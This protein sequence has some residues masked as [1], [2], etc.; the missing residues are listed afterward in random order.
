MTTSNIHL[1]LQDKISLLP[2]VCWRHERNILPFYEA[3]WKSLGI[4]DNFTRKIFSGKD[5]L[6]GFGFSNKERKLL[7]QLT[8]QEANTLAER[9]PED[10]ALSR[11]YFVEIRRVLPMLG[12][13]RRTG[14]TQHGPY[15]IPGLA[16]AIKALAYIIYSQ[17]IGH[18]LISRDEFIRIASFP[19]ALTPTAPSPNF[20]LQLDEAIYSN[21]K[22]D[23]EVLQ[24]RHAQHLLEGFINTCVH[25]SRDVDWSDAIKHSGGLDCPL[26]IFEL[27]ADH[28]WIL[29]WLF[30]FEWFA[31]K[32]LLC[33]E[34]LVL[35][36]LWKHWHTRNNFI[37]DCDFENHAISWSCEV[38]DHYA[39]W[40]TTLPQDLHYQLIPLTTQEDIDEESGVLD[41]L[42][43]CLTPD[44]AIGR[45]RLFSIRETAT[46]RRIA[47]AEISRDD[48]EGIWKG[49]G[50]ND[51]HDGSL[52]FWKLDNPML[53]MQHISALINAAAAWYNRLARPKDI[54]F[55]FQFI[56]ALDRNGRITR[57]HGHK[58]VYGMT[59]R[60]LSSPTCEQNFVDLCFERGM[61]LLGP[62]YAG[63]WPECQKTL[64][65]D[66]WSSR[67]VAD[68]KRFV[69]DV[70]VGDWIILR[71][72]SG[73]VLGI[74]KVVGDYE[75]LTEFENVGG[76]DMQHARPVTW[77]WKVSK[78]PNNCSTPALKLITQ[79][80][81]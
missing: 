14:S 56:A 79:I 37:V 1:Q 12:L 5:L 55:S 50:I 58:D 19:T 7:W 33:E 54:A 61:I 65:T 30:D 10:V 73:T 70:K 45:S 62:G 57:D 49:S 16:D 40:S 80:T 41:N 4:S 29:K 47:T 43:W 77:L 69:E 63:S 23:S 60:Q 18:T 35:S 66:E 64:R 21:G 32:T 76:W 42:S 3:A 48:D 24:L 31:G 38:A 68:I 81:Y 36:T 78:T 9:M 22:R 27:I 34:W 20:Q 51:Q 2:F 26:P 74:G 46:G 44:C 8:S 53:A 28:T 6:R 17:D 52:D 13:Q 11:A 67:K 39:Q 59:I 75:W 15:L 25:H 71:N 72:G